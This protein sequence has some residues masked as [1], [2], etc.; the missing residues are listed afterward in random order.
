M[1]R[2]PLSIVVLLS[3][4]ISRPSADESTS[5]KQSADDTLQ[6][7]VFP[8]GTDDVTVP[9]YRADTWLL[10]RVLVG[11][12]DAGWFLVDTGATSTIIDGNVADKLGLRAVGASNVK[13]TDGNSRDATGFV[14]VIARDLRVGSISLPKAVALRGDLSF[15]ANAGCRLSGALGLDFLGAVPITLDF[16]AGSITF[17]RPDRFKA[18]TDADKVR[19]PFAVEDRD[20]TGVY[21]SADLESNEGRFDLDTGDISEISVE[22]WFMRTGKALLPRRHSFRS[23]VY[24]IGGM[25]SSL[26]SQ[27]E[28]FELFGRRFEDVSGSYPLDNPATS[29]FWRAGKIGAELLQDARLTIDCPGKRL[30][31]EWLP[32]E[33]PDEMIARLGGVGTPDLA[34]FTPLIRAACLGRT[35]IVDALITAGVDVNA[36]TKMDETALMFAASRGY[37]QCVRALLA[38]GAKLNESSTVLAM[39]ALHRAA[40]QGR[41]DVVGEL[42]SRGADPNAQMTNGRTPLMCAAE[43]GWPEVVRLLLEKG[44]DVSVASKENKQT[45][46]RMGAL[47]EGE[48]VAAILEARPPLEA[49]DATGNTALAY[50]AVWGQPEATR[51]LVAAGAKIETA[52]NEGLTP[53]MLAAS[54]GEPEV[55][56]YLLSCGADLS[57]KSKA[58]KTATDY[59]LSFG[60]YPTIKTLVLAADDAKAPTSRP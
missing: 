34:G 44:A 26:S 6:G 30:W 36:K 50:A 48:C 3:L 25:S 58:G 42:L 32:E 16:R 9:L 49:R 14:P 1:Y 35:D 15:T 45:A 28:R 24:S 17:H 18:P 29:P 11:D 5:S 20:G 4:V 51:A 23:P 46:L 39:T 47:S 7:L 56:R 57:A 22:R 43:A 27:F 31:C 60:Q 8:S 41:R 37:L 40:Y 52:D 2:I 13:L 21:V 53:L 33:K 38:A 12:N 55:V 54:R 59:A 19:G 10:A